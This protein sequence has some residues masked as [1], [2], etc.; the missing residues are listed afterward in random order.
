M[1]VLALAAAALSTTASFAQPASFAPHRAVYEIS[2]AQG[3][4]ADQGRV[5]QAR[6]RLVYEFTGS[7]CEGWSTN[8]RFV[9][10][11]Q[12]GGG[13]T[14]LSDIRSTTHE[15][16][17]GSELRFVT[18]S[19]VNNMVRDQADG[20]ARRDGERVRVELTR[21]ER[22]S[23]DLPGTV[24]FPTQH[25]V[26][27]LAATRRGERLFSL[28]IYDGSEGG[29]KVY[30]TT[31]IL[32]RTLSGLAE[33]HPAHAVEALRD[34]PRQPMSISFFEQASGRGE[35]LPLYELKVEVYENGITHSLVIDYGSFGLR[36]TMTSLEMLPVTPCG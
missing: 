15:A 33:G 4:R 20:V 6:G 7:Q 23:F 19:M 28:D 18:R 36:G 24:A 1:T 9:T 21:P 26:Q 22:R 35:Q 3:G 32:G 14:H 10:E 30:A 17:D 13:R 11:L 12:I 27:A 2:L 8:L 31:A 34:A 25:L 5:E 16:G 29:Q